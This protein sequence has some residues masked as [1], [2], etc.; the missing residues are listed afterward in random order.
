[1][2]IPNKQHA[3]MR[4]TKGENTMRKEIIATTGEELEALE[5]EYDLEDCGMSG[6]HIGMHWLSD[7]EA[8]VDVYFSSNIFA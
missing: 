8:E 6:S 5:I 1:M 7:D 3:A 2:Y 4:T